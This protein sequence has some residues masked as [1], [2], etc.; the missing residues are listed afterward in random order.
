MSGSNSKTFESYINAAGLKITDCFMSKN[1]N[2]PEKEIE[3]YYLEI[4]HSNENILT[5]ST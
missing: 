2:Q 4:Q 1:L 5:C 3:I